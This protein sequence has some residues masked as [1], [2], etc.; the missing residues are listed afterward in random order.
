M[1]FRLNEPKQLTTIVTGYELDSIFISVPTNEIAL[2]YDELGE[3]DKV[4][5]E[6]SLTIDGEDFL[7][8]FAG[9]NQMIL[10]QIQSNNPDILEN[11]PNLTVDLHKALGA[12][13]LMQ[14]GA[15]NSEVGT[16]E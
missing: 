11:Y 9:A 4:V 6:S 12:F 1:P 10:N 2:A 15:S 13:L 14:I 7:S 8:A 3:A 5:K 16:V